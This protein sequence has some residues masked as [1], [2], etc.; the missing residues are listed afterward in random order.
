MADTSRDSLGR[1][2][3][4]NVDWATA[5]CHGGTADGTTYRLPG[6]PSVSSNSQSSARRLPHLALR[7]CRLSRVPTTVLRSPPRILRPPA[8]VGGPV[9]RPRPPPFLLSL[10]RTG[11]AAAG[12]LICPIHRS[13]IQPFVAG[14]VVLSSPVSPDLAVLFFLSLCCKRYGICEWWWPRFV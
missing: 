3:K 8:M 9:S 2:C 12:P 1:T 13:E 7:Y 10:P 5:T 11:G 14:H 6:F 4:P